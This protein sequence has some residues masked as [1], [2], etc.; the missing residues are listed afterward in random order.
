MGVGQAI[1]TFLRL[2]VPGFEPLLQAILAN[3]VKGAIKEFNSSDADMTPAVLKHI[4]EHGLKAEDLL[5]TMTELRN[6]DIR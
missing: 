3:E 2:G 4:P 6:K 1:I 5:A